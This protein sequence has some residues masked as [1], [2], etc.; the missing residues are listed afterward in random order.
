MGPSTATATKVE[1]DGLP[2]EIGENVV[3]CSLHEGEVKKAGRRLS[4]TSIA[5]VLAI[6]IWFIRILYH[7]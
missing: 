7:K 6:L 4:V 1:E 2:E 3:G 5:I